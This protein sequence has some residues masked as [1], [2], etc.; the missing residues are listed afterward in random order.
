MK[1]VLS[2]SD[3][4]TTSVGNPPLTILFTLYYYFLMKE[5]CFLWIHDSC[6][7]RSR[8]WQFNIIWWMRIVFSL[9][10]DKASFALASG[11]I[12]LIVE[13][14]NAFFTSRDERSPVEEKSTGILSLYCLHEGN[15]AALKAAL[16]FVDHR[17]AWQ[18]GIRGTENVLCDICR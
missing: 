13:S 12:P 8:G 1:S 18:E 2:F 10:S 16:L 17:N 14:I 3:E 11:T 4:F 9:R 5:N 7:A 15:V 6:Q